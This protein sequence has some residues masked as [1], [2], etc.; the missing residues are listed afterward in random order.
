MI[1]KIKNK[2]V[3][4]KCNI[5]VKSEYNILRREK[6]GIDNM[7]NVQNVYNWD[8]L[9]KVLK[10]VIKTQK[11]TNLVFHEDEFGFSEDEIHFT[12]TF[13]KFGD[14]IV[15]H[16]DVM[17]TVS[18]KSVTKTFHNKWNMKEYVEAVCGW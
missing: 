12:I 11:T 6:K 3:L 10:N 2:K 16:Y 14:W 17:E 9:Q 7:K 18:T 4:K 1:K 15:T 8:E 13:D 5:S